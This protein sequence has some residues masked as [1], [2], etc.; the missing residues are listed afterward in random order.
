MIYVL[1][2]A[3]AQLG[4]AADGGNL[5]LHPC[6]G[7]RLIHPGEHALSAPSFSLSTPAPG[8]PSFTGLPFHP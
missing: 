6:A 1:V 4:A 7:A 2:P 3:F 8:T 5:S